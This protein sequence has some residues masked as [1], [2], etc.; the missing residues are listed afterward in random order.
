MISILR[1][2]QPTFER[3]AHIL[4]TF[5]EYMLGITSKTHYIDIT[6]SNFLCNPFAHLL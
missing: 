5:P 2:F 3:D 1:A 6:L 4:L